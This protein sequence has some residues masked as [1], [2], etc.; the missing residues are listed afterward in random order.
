MRSPAPRA[1]LAIAS[2][3]VAL[4]AA[5]TYV[6]VLA[7]TDMMTG[8][9]IGIDSLQ[10]ATP[11]IS[12]F[13]L[14]YV[15]VLPLIG[16]IADLVPRQRVLLTCLAIFVL[17]SAV[18]ALAV[19]APVLVAGRVVQG[20]GGGGLVP[21]TLAIVADLWPAD[22]RGTP[23]GVV[24]AVQELGAV[25][26]PLLGALILAVSDWRAIFWVNAVLGVLLGAGIA[27]TGGGIRRPS[28]A[29]ASPRSVVTGTDVAD[30]RRR[31]RGRRLTAAG[32]G[33]LA[34]V[35]GTLALAA[36]TAL[37]NDVTLG[38][39]FVPFGASTSRVLTPIGTA[40]AVLALSAVVVAGPRW[41]P[42]L[43]RADL[44]GAALLGATLGL[45]IVTFASAD[46]EREVVGPL[47]LALL[48]L[49]AVTAG[50]YLWRH[51]RAAEPLVPRGVVGGL[52]RVAL[53]VSL[54][55]GVA[56]VAVVVDVPLLARLVL[57]D[58][59]T[60]AALVLV[61]FLVA[62]PVGA[63]VGGWSLRVLGDGAVAAA[64]LALAAS[65]LVAMST[66]DR[67]ALSHPWATVVL[68]AV[69]LGVGLT[70]APVN[71]AALAD[72][73]DHAH[74]TASALVVVARMVGMVVGLAL[75]TAIGLHKYYEAVAVLPDQTDPKA[76]VAAGLVQV[77]WVFRGA[78]VAATLGALAAL[79]LG[80][81]RSVVSPPHGILDR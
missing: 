78:A 79:R 65:G 61:R 47:G 33:L 22:R 56:L 38:V 15:A 20:V 16:R 62:V 5:D 17:G 40:A 68:V 81:A 12:G 30:A 14:G 10:R 77:H 13:L 21:A 51:R 48:P 7:L 49:A 67:A 39:P 24:G 27:V 37:A 42:T 46:P 73:P 70:L 53:T 71:N 35:C 63:L 44:P 3:A 23:L 11:I 18:T 66:W 6:V 57:T 60:V 45:V 32:C 4:A 34:L 52:S 9:G 41:W 31:A 76:L 19:D 58:S 43:R 59:Q 1:L 75:L 25:L 54:A 55:V 29:R 74:G 72:A 28:P 69:G 50:L 36:P 26:G 2:A 64:G 8:V 80:L